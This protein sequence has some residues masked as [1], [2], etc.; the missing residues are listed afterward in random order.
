M[1]AF[2]TLVLFALSSASLTL[3]TAA[4]PIPNGGT[5]DSSKG[6]FNDLS[7]VTTSVE[8]LIHSEQ[9]VD[10]PLQTAKDPNSITGSGAGSGSGGV[11][12]PDSNIKCDSGNNAFNVGLLRPTTQQRV[13]LGQPFLV[14]YCSPTYH[15][16]RSMGWDVLAYNSNSSGTMGRLLGMNINSPSTHVTIDDRYY[17]RLAVYER[18]TGYAGNQFN[19]ITRDLLFDDNQDANGKKV[20]DAVGQ[21]SPNVSSHL[22]GAWV[23]YHSGTGHINNKRSLFNDGDKAAAAAAIAAGKKAATAGAHDLSAAEKKAKHEM[24]GLMADIK[25]AANNVKRSPINEGDKAAMGAAIAAGKKAAKA[26]AHD[27]SAVQKEG[28]HAVAGILANNSNNN[29]SLLSADDKAAAT[30]G[31]DAGL[32]GINAGLHDLGSAAKKAVHE[33]EGMVAGIKDAAALP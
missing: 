20:K 1:L 32:Q 5:K 19:M 22:D 2:R 16:T 28:Q 13:T 17:D 33:A 29:K 4:A 15:A 31:M 7:N 30:A 6:A 14:S 10:G 12:V 24:G 18:Q 27:V 3:F 21:L 11:D 25:H 23:S 8:G 9:A 26:G